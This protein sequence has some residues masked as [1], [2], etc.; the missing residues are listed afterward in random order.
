MCSVSLPSDSVLHLVLL[1]L[2]VLYG[3]MMVWLLGVT[4]KMMENSTSSLLICCWIADGKTNLS[5]V[6]KSLIIRGKCKWACCVCGIMLECHS[7]GLW[8]SSS[9]KQH[10]K[11][12]VSI[13]I[14]TTVEPPIFF[15]C[16]CTQ[17]TIKA[18]GTRTCHAKQW[19]TPPSVSTV[20]IFIDT[21][22]FLFCFQLQKQ[23]NFH[24]PF[25]WYSTIKANTTHQYTSPF[26]FSPYN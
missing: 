12:N 3:A 18:D 23:D 16:Y 2:M 20:G 4:A 9:W 1:E 7:N 25:E 21:L 13:E 10:R 17:E 8:E 6:C 5:G 24:N 11:T 19:S 22:F 15:F 14:P 26:T